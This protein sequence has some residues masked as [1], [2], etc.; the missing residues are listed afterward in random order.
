[1]NDHP[2]RPAD[3]ASS[4]S[5]A[6]FFD[7]MSTTRND[8][9]RTNPVLDYEQQVRSATVLRL[10]QPRRGDTILD[11]GCGNAR[12]IVPMLQAGAT[13]VGVDISEGMIEQGRR[14]LARAGVTAGVTLQVGD[15][16]AL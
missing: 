15:A 7:E 5:I 2:T 10:L 3:S 1:M 6:S 4:A 16:T 9:F 12:D 11:I 8:V 13:V 14:D